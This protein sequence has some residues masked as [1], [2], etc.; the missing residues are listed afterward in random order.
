MMLMLMMF[1]FVAHDSVNLNAQCAE[2]G[3]GEGGED[4]EK[5]IRITQRAT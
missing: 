4:R 3:R 1:T 2:A 5:V